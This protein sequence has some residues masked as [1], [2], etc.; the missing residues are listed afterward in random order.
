MALTADE[1]KLMR[2]AIMQ[3]AFNQYGDDPSGEPYYSVQLSVLVNT[4]GLADNTVRDIL[5]P[6]QTSY[7]AQLQPPAPNPILATVQAIIIQPDT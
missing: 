3:G 6:F 1:K 7:I 4:A 2:Y 5:R